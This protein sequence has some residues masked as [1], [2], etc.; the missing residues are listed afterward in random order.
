MLALA[1]AVVA[2]S[3]HR[4]RPGPWFAARASRACRDAPYAPPPR[5]ATSSYVL[6]IDVA[7]RHMG[8]GRRPRRQ[9]PEQVHLDLWVPDSERVGTSAVALF[10]DGSAS[11]A[12]VA[13]AG[14]RRSSTAVLSRLAQR[15]RARAYETIARDDQRDANG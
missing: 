10:P 7:G 4:A 12:R 2:P 14:M 11:G 9:L 5:S 1:L 3:L 13:V 6:T 15:R 8:G